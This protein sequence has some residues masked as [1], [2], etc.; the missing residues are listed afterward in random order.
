MLAE[1]S[2]NWANLKETAHQ[3]LNTLVASIVKTYQ[4]QRGSYVLKQV[5]SAF[6]DG[7]VMLRRCQKARH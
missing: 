3:I 7:L 1:V 5:R 4:M 2:G 6:A